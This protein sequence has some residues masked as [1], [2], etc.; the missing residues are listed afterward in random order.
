LYCRLSDR[1]RAVSCANT[2]FLYKDAPYLILEGD[3]VRRQ[4]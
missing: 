4:A 3:A 1:E 2:P